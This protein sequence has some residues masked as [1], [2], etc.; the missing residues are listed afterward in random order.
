MGQV[1]AAVLALALAVVIFIFDAVYSTR[2]RPSLRGLAEAVR[3]PAIFYAGMLAVGLTG[4]VLVG[5]GC[6]ASSGC[7]A[8]SCL[9]PSIEGQVRPSLRR[10]SRPEY[11]DSG[12]RH[13]RPLPGGH[14]IID[15]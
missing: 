10:Q 11:A 1:Q 12:A 6:G 13:V 9:R 7:I 3:L 14:P 4:M 8:T 15:A 2:L 5:G